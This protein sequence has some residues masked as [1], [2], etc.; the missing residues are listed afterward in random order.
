MTLSEFFTTIFQNSPDISKL[1][2]V[3]LL[4]FIAF[5]PISLVISAFIKSLL[6]FITSI[7]LTA[8][9]VCCM[10]TITLFGLAANQT[11]SACTVII[12]SFTK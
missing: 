5:I 9:W 12:N 7:V 3:I 4:V 1:L 11:N 10:L 6:P 8:T 2:I